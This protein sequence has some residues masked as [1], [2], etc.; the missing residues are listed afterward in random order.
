MRKIAKLK[1]SIKNSFDTQWEPISD[2]ERQ[3]NIGLQM[4]L[5]RQRLEK[6]LGRPLKRNELSNTRKGVTIGP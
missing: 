3:Q 4:D 1:E 5:E 6:E 2:F